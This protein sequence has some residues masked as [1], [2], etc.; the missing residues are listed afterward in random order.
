MVNKRLA[1]RG[2]G[3]NLMMGVVPAPAIYG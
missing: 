1:K 3:A 2:A